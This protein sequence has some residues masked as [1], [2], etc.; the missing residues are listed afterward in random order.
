MLA[1][2]DPRVLQKMHSK[3]IP[4][5]FLAGVKYDFGEGRPVGKGPFI[6]KDNIEEIRKILGDLSGMYRGSRRRFVPD[7]AHYYQ[8]TKKS[9]K[10]RWMKISKT[11]LRKLLGHFQA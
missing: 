2:L 1:S 11:R 10:R 9:L 8:R 6:N 4:S 5:L 3:V 7:Y